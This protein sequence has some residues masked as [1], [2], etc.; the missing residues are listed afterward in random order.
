MYKTSPSFTTVCVYI[1]NSI[2][3]QLTCSVHLRLTQYKVYIFIYGHRR[4]RNAFVQF[5]RLLLFVIY[6]QCM[7]HFRIAPGT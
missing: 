5:I 7:L 2:V 3:V 6:Q 1:L 4:E